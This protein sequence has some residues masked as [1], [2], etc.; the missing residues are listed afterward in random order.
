MKDFEEQNG[1][2]TESPDQP[3]TDAADD[4]HTGGA[5]SRRR[6]LQVG[7]AGAAG[8]AMTR[9]VGL[10]RL[11]G[12]AEGPAAK[13]TFSVTKKAP[14]TFWV[15]SPFTPSPSAAIYTAIADY[16]KANNAT[17]TLESVDSNTLDDKLIVAVKA[18]AGPD[19]VSIDVNNAPVLASAGVLRGIGSE[20]ASIKDNFAPGGV[21][22]AQYN[23]I[24]YS[25][26]W[27]TNNLGLF[28][29]PK[30]LEKAGVSKAPTDWTELVDAC[31]A[32]TNGKQYGIMYGADGY[33]SYQW[34]PFLWQ[35]GGSVLTPDGKKAAFDN[36]AGIEAWEFFADLYLT[37]H[38]VPPAVV[39]ANSSWD[40]ITQP[41]AEE[42]VAMCIIG[43]YGILPVQEAAPS[44]K[45]EVVPLPKNVYAATILG[46]FN[47]AIPRTSTQV[48]AA[49]DFIEWMVAPKQTWIL[50]AYDRMSTLKSAEHS[51]YAENPLHAG[52]VAQ[53]SVA[54]ALP[55]ITDMGNINWTYIANA[56]D[57]TITRQGSPES[58]LR[59]AAV[60]TNASL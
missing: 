9:S 44:L 49:W 46:G 11:A 35:N 38:D 57:A 59:K 37:H 36:A 19:V 21:A 23:G 50:D 10:G 3:V 16:E 40:Q 32:V 45:F 13:K 14:I 51:K 30:M 60:Q 42:Q 22:A 56:W 25:V 8:L 29:N 33:G 6:V 48:S 24:Q 17:V 5:I 55:P 28:V 43:D 58:E 47:F 54:R 4:Q 41:F 52:F 39:A 26:P 12:S 15:I 34:F 1:E 20:F 31:D 7:V 27:Y 18:G 2:Q 53:A